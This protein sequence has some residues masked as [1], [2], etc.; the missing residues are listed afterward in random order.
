[1]GETTRPN[2]IKISFGAE[3]TSVFELSYLNIEDLYFDELEDYIGGR[4]IHCHMRVYFMRLKKV[5][6]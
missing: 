4:N 1:M 2:S 3:Q 6:G 5:L